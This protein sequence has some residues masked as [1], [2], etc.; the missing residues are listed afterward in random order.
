[1]PRWLR[2]V[3]EEKGGHGERLLIQKGLTLSDVMGDKG[4]D[5]NAGTVVTVYI[6]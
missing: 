5:F 3:V 4:P 6:N 2:D 1:M